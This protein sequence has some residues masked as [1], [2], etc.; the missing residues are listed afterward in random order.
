M[1]ARRVASGVLVLNGVRALESGRTM[2]D[3]GHHRAVMMMMVV[4]HDVVIGMPVTVMDD[5]MRMVESVMTIAM[6]GVVV[7]VVEGRVMVG[8]VH[9]DDLGSDHR[10]I[11]GGRARARGGARR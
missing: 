1:L 5:R 10:F 7:T 11:L 8:M 2:V 6:I 3:V 4:L 9:H